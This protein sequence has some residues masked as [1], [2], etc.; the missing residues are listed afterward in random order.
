MPEPPEI[1]TKT[2]LTPNVTF[3]TPS[4][5]GRRYSIADGDEGFLYYDR[6]GAEADAGNLVSDY[7]APGM[8]LEHGT[9]YSPLYCRVK[10]GGNDRNKG[11][12]DG[13]IPRPYLRQ[14]PQITTLAKTVVLP[15]GP[16]DS[17]Y[18]QHVYSF[19]PNDRT[20]VAAS[21]GTQAYSY[22]T[23]WDIV[24][25]ADG[26]F[27]EMVQKASGNDVDGYMFSRVSVGYPD[28]PIGAVSPTDTYILPESGNYQ[29]VCP[30]P[31]F[32]AG[33]R[34]QAISEAGQAYA[35]SQMQAG[36]LSY[37]YA[38]QII[39][40]DATWMLYC[41]WRGKPRLYRNANYVPIENYWAWAYPPTWQYVPWTGGDLS[42]IDPETAAAKGYQYHIGVVKGNLCVWE[43]DWDGEC[44]YFDASGLGEPVVPRGSLYMQNYPGQCT[45]WLDLVQGANEVKIGRRQFWVGGN[46]P[47]EITGDVW[48]GPGDVTRNING[49]EINDASVLEGVVGNTADLDIFVDTS[50]REY[51]DY[52]VSLRPGAYQTIDSYNSAVVPDL[53]TYT[54]PFVEAVTVWQPTKLTD[55][56]ALNFQSHI[57]IIPQGLSLDEALEASRA[58]TYNLKFGNNPVGF[59]KSGLTVPEEGLPRTYR[60]QPGRQ[61]QAS[62]NWVEF[63]TA[64]GES[65]QGET[66]QLGQYTLV[67]VGR[68]RKQA[69]AVATDLLGLAALG[70]WS[71]TELNFRGWGL[72]EALEFGC[73]MLAIGSTERDFED[74]G[75]DSMILDTDD[76][77]SYKAGT[78]WA[79]IFTDLVERYGCGAVLY[80]DGSDNKLKTGCRYCRSKRNAESD[81]L[82]NYWRYHQDNGWASSGCL[83]NDLLREDDGVDFHIMDD[84]DATGAE[85]DSMYYTLKPVEAKVSCL[86]REGYA[87]EVVGTAKTAQGLKIT[88]RARSNYAFDTGNDQYVGVRVT[89]VV[90]FT[91]EWGE[92]IGDLGWTQEKLNDRVVEELR[93]SMAWPLDAQATLPFHAEIRPGMTAQIH[94]GSYC[95]VDQKMF[96]ITG[97]SHNVDSRESTIDLHEINAV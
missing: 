2:L 91:D 26:L 92:D 84:P 15:L 82:T 40:G 60:I 51:V 25:S 65:S 79:E 57:E 62:M 11:A 49:V 69:D 9:M 78:P 13:F 73:D 22:L 21:G 67:R 54:F 90:D 70:K 17:D 87:N 39:W 14:S 1:N 37:L 41:P 29:G 72:M 6:L 59:D 43:G 5:P 47:A 89:K 66:V 85:M 24:P 93:A 94:G 7:L 46:K 86:T 3:A 53:W 8:G 18:L 16:W 83:A 44:A 20:E 77:A 10:F 80:Y 12:V 81:D 30:N 61:I 34:H 48:G 96:R 68:D 56:G 97:C 28:P 71:R 31:F 35:I 64:T 23:Y 32:V 74:L 76:S 38:T 19:I 58:Q 88:A 95:A 63:D 55:G 75:D 45:Y 4:S 42:D 36:V 52:V 50:T 33:F 27:W